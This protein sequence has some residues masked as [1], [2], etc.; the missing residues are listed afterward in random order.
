[1]LVP[2]EEPAVMEHALTYSELVQLV[3]DFKGPLTLVALETQVLQMQLDDGAHADMVDAIGRVL[4]NVN[5]ID[6]MMHGLID[7]WAIETGHFVL[8]RKST[9]LRDLLENVVARMTL[10][11]ERGRIVLE[12]RGRATL[13]IDALRIERVIANLVYNALVY[14]SEDTRVTVSFTT[15]AE[16]ARISVRDDGPGIAPA[17]LEHLFDE[18]RRGSVGQT[19]DGHGLG[20]FVSKQI[21]QAHGGV[22]GVESTVGV[23]SEFFFELPLK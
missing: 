23:G 16:A 10:S 9:E 17:E 5:Y 15:T 4:L 13:D 1:M 6:R 18:A 19:H 11:R 7:S 3:H 12:A 21:I 20:L 8:H 2:E 14:S 22:I